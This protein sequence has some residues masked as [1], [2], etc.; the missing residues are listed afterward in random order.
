MMDNNGSDSE[1]N[2][3]DDDIVIEEYRNPSVA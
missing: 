2:D 1:N 3:V